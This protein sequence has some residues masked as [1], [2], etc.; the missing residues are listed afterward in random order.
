MYIEWKVEKKEI[1]VENREINEIE[2]E[3]SGEKVI[4]WHWNSLIGNKRVK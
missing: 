1:I 4:R 3:I 2:Q